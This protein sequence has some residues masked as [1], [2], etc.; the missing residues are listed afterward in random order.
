MDIDRDEDL[1]NLLPVAVKIPHQK[2]IDFSNDDELSIR[3]YRYAILIQIFA[4]K[5]HFKRD[6]KLYGK[7]ILY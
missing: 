4:Y 6:L 5:T 2:G 1:S 7:L 3:I